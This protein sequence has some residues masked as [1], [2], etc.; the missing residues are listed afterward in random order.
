MKV[1]NLFKVWLQV[2]N[3]GFKYRQSDSRGYMLSFCIILA[4]RKMMGGLQYGCM[5]AEGYDMLCL[6]SLL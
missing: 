2:V 1:N 3:S 5:E 6:I 4:E